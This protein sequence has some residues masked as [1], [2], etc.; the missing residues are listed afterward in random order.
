M[1]VDFF[2]LS[3]IFVFLIIYILHGVSYIMYKIMDNEK[4]EFIP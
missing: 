3:F 1:L 2:F 4:I